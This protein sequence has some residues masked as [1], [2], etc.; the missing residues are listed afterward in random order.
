MKNVRFLF[1]L[2]VLAACVF[3]GVSCSKTGTCDECGNK[4]VKLYKVVDEDKTLYL[5]SDCKKS[6]EI[7]LENEKIL[8][9]QSDN[10]KGKK[11][12]D[13]YS[14]IS[15][16]ETYIVDSEPYIVR[17]QVVLGYKKND[18]KTSSEITSR[19]IEI[20]DILRN[21]F[22]KQ[23]RESLKTSNERALR[24]EI[25][26]LI[27]ESVLENSKILDVRFTNLEVIQK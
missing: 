4:N 11:A 23:T 9:E 19:K 14:S 24:L 2:I 26:K 8:S 27:N 16:L 13:W 3:G 25:L 6:Y 21:F 15:Q 17:V 5:C 7:N 10:V 20:T 22:S 18:K 1:V 12:Y